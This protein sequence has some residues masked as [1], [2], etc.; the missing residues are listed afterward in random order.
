MLLLSV[1]AKLVAIKCTEGTLI[2][3]GSEK[4]KIEG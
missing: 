4:G 1:V 2:G 3:D